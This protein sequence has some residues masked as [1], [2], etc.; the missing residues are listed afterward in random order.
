MSAKA[1]YFRLGLFVIIC[2]GIGVVIIM[3]L[4][5][6]KSFE[7]RVLVET[8]A[9]ESVQGLD[10][11][12]KVKFRGVRLGQVKE[13]GFTSG[14]YE[15]KKKT[16]DRKG[17]IYI[18]MELNPVKLKGMAPRD[19]LNQSGL[20][21]AI[22]QGLRCRLK[23][24]GITGLMYLDFDLMNPDTN[25]P[26]PID[27][28]P[29]E[30]Y[31]PSAPSTA[32][33]FLDSADH[34]LRRVSNLKIEEIIH[35][36]NTVLTTMN[37]KLE[38]MQTEQL[39]NEATRLLGELR[40]TNQALL[41][42]LRNP[43][44]GNIQK[45]VAASLAGVRKLVDNPKIPQSIDLVCANLVKLDQMLNKR[46]NDLA[47]SLDNL[48]QVSENLRAFSEHLQQYPTGVLLSEPPLPS[49]PPRK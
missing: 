19:G 11:G 17:Y 13:V 9:D 3:M 47:V 49:Q 12:S 31:V 18:L 2:L 48:R 15:T 4:G 37:A 21:I 45:D 30:L 5:V 46:D 16:A 27:W 24:E 38:K 7:P 34:L 14:I 43:N 23:S 25:P 35:N 22:A 10:V 33:K 40:Q 20:D 29:E 44:N 39:N 8:Y 28:K 42:V 36:L 6:F 41:D 26:L 32:T 1:N